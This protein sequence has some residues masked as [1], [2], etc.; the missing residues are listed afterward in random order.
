LKAFVTYLA[1]AAV[2]SGFGK[3]ATVSLTGPAVSYS[4]YKTCSFTGLSSGG[5]T[6]GS[7]F[8]TAG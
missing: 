5:I 2:D 7:G 6:I 8:L 1:G 3:A 4:D